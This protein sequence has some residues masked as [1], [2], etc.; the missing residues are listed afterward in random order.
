MPTVNEQEKENG[1]EKNEIPIQIIDRTK[2]MPTNDGEIEIPIT[3]ENIE[4]GKNPHP[5][6][7]D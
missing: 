2:L 4:K 5:H 1:S 6:H 3:G 7:R